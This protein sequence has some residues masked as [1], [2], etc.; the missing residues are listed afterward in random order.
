MRRAGVVVPA[1]EADE[2]VTAVAIVGDVVNAVVVNIGVERDGGIL[3]R[4][5][6][7]AG[8]NAVED[9]MNLVTAHDRAVAPTQDDACALVRAS[10]D[11]IP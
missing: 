9:V 1:V 11:G 8:I 3:A 2:I 10:L 5:T 6:R 4:R 7:H